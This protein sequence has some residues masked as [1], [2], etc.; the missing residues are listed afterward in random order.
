[1]GLKNV[2]CKKGELELINCNYKMST[3]GHNKDVSIQCILREDQKLKNITVHVN[4]IDIN[5]PSAEH[6]AVVS[7]VLH[8][9]TTDEPT[10]FAVKCSNEQQMKWVHL[11]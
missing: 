6:I 9:T 2:G 11:W 1:M 7:W 10:S 8:N 3:C 4:I 5:V